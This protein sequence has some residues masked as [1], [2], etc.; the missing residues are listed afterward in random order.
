MNMI[1]YR[2][3]ISLVLKDE[4]SWSSQMN[5]G[6]KNVLHTSEKWEGLQG[7]FVWSK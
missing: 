3:Y 4:E 1:L 5:L 2:D 6:G 7:E